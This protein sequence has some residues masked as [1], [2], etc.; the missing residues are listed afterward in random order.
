MRILGVHFKNF[1]SYKEG[2]I[3]LDQ[4]GL[5]LLQGKTGA[6]K[7]TIQDAVAW[8]LFGITA[9]DGAADDVRNWNTNEATYVCVT[10]LFSDKNIRIHRT[11]GAGK[12]DLF[13][14][15][16]TFAP[17][18][19]DAEAQIRGKDLTE[20][21]KL[22]NAE[23]GVTPELFVAASY[24]HEFSPTGS[25]FT[26]KAKDRREL[27]EMLA[28]LDLPTTLAT[29]VKDKKSALKEEM[30]QVQKEY[31]KITHVYNTSA[32]N[33]NANEKERQNW[34]AN[35]K[36]RVARIVKAHDDFEQDRKAKD[37]ELRAIISKKESEID[38]VMQELE[39]LERTILPDDYFKAQY[40][41][42]EKCHA[43]DQPLP[44]HKHDKVNQKKAD[45]DQKVY[46]Q[47]VLMSRLEGLNNS[48]SPYKREL[49]NLYKQKNPY[50]TQLEN[51]KED[52]NPFEAKAPM[53]EK[54]LVESALQ[55][56][57]LQEKQ[58]SIYHQYKLTCAM[59]DIIPVLR[60]ELLKNS[61]MGIEK[62]T[63]TYLETYFDAEL[64][65][66]FTAEEDNLTVKIFKSGNDCSY[67]Q[68]S[69]GQRGLLKLCFSVAVMS[70]ASNRAGVHFENLFF[71]EALDGLDTEL[72]IK[73]FKLFEML[74][75]GRSSILMVDHAPEFQNMFSKTFLVTL[76]GDTSKLEERHG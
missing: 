59:S 74:E 12:N 61:I 10:V 3:C 46:R 68:L 11:R 5:A 40:E 23:I 50:L 64:R 42:A 35:Q 49:N 27:F 41:T 14:T 72:K 24:Y 36:S 17:P 4:L 6:G 25:F 2:A 33:Y 30:E 67:K 26:A 70:A 32:E 34:V 56:E 54:K 62:L 29:K 38:A 73:A 75:Q 7:S 21:Q 20:T 28:N 31:L 55:Y 43:C 51:E 18:Y 16:A 47:A 71:D 48:L 39:Q 63:N 1:G 66:A 65:V 53:L 57:D 69:K 8:G 52:K 60:G 13:F 9:K 58:K 22:L 37:L 19:S 76:D 15:K 44:T 45:N